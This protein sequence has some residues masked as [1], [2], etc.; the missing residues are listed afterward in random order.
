MKK[1]KT[2]KIF[3]RYF[4]L[5]RDILSVFFLR[6]FFGVYQSIE[7]KSRN[8]GLAP[9]PKPKFRSLVLFVFFGKFGKK[10]G[11]AKNQISK[12]KVPKPHMFY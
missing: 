8:F 5:S 2:K 10:L 1:K 3:H 4:F 7:K 9:N 11:S 6:Y 12:K